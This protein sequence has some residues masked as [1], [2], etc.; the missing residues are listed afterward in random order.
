MILKS[1]VEI[2]SATE[3][4]IENKP[5]A[6]LAPSTAEEAHLAREVQ[7]RFQKECEHLSATTHRIREYHK[8]NIKFSQNRN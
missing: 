6:P 2:Y 5:N 4:D 3:S 8:T 1:K 7:K